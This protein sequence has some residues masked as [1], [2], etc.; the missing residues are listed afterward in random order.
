M[1]KKLHNFIHKK[2]II[3]TLIAQLLILSQGTAIS[4]IASPQEKSQQ[5]FEYTETMRHVEEHLEEHTQNDFD[6]NRAMLKTNL[7]GKMREFDIPP[8]L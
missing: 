5:Y 4:A 8:I 2:L 7:R 6:I 1:K 3:I